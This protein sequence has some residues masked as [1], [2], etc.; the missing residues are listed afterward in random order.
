MAA[1]FHIRPAS[2]ALNDDYLFLNFIDSQLP[3]L[4]QQG[5]E[6]QWGSTPFSKDEKS[7]AKYRGKVQ[8]SE[9]ADQKWDLNWV[10]VYIAEVDASNTDVLRDM[11]IQKS[12]ERHSVNPMRLPVAA[13]ILTGSSADYTRSVIPA[14]DENNPFMWVYWLVSDRRVGAASRGS[15]QAL[16]DYAASMAQDLGLRRLC[17]DCW[18]GNNRRLVQ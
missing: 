11:D 18:N 1:K 8:R 7:I 10:K 17:L 3:W 9:V 6:G 5:S 13:M 2:T 16:L 15:G 4:A 14:Q 12:E